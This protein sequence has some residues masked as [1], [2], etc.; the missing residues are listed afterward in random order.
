MATRTLSIDIVDNDTLYTDQIKSWIDQ[1]ARNAVVTEYDSYETALQGLS[2]YT[3]DIV[4]VETG[5]RAGNGMEFIRKMR[6]GN[7]DVRMLVLTHQDELLYAERALRIGA[8][9]YLMKDVGYDVFAQAMDALLRDEF[10][11]SETIEGKILKSLAA[12][13]DEEDIDPE[14]KLSNRE[15]E[16]FVKIGEGMS[17][18]EVADLLGISIKTVETHRAH[19]K[20]KLGNRSAKDLQ[21][22]AADWVARTY[23]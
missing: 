16:I 15:L 17:S 8:H 20:R 22:K 14:K 13:P 21:R 4:I 18:K 19:I 9:G 12:Q 6:L 2:H 10:F 5:M 11:V 7:P 1:Y 23:A 3:P